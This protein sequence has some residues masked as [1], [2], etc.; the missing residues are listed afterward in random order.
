MPAKPKTKPASWIQYLNWDRIFEYAFVIFLA[1][2]ALGATGSYGIP[3]GI[4]ALGFWIRA[5]NRQID[6]QNSGK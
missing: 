4:L 2:S 3:A 6:R 1:I 5:K